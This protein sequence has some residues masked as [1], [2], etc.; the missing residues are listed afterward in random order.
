MERRLIIN[1]Y[2]FPG[3]NVSQRYEEDVFVENLHKCVGF[4]G[5]VYVVSSVSTAAAIQTPTTIYGADAKGLTVGAA[6]CLCVG[7][8]FAGVFCDLMAP[9]E[10]P[11]GEATLA[12]DWRGSDSQA[13]GEL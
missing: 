11:G 4:A 9:L 6:I 5:V 3:R 2:L 13:G 1:G 12:V 8:Y 7:D 10:R